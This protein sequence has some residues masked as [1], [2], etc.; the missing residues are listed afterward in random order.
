[1]SSHTD[2]F[3][4]SGNS[5]TADSRADRGVASKSQSSVPIVSI[6]EPLLITSRQAARLLSVSPAEI[7]LLARKGVLAY[8]KLSPRK[9][10]FSLRSVRQ[11]A[12][13]TNGRAV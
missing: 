9:W 12:E 8:R 4:S 6:P 11:F 13:S 1:M 7:R 10:L 3:T 5:P 2:S